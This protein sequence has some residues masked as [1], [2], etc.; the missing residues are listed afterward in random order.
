MLPI[1]GA[2]SSADGLAIG[3]NCTP[4]KIA[5]L[6]YYDLAL[7][8]RTLMLCPVDGGAIAT[9]RDSFRLAAQTGE[10]ML[11]GALAQTPTR[12]AAS[13]AVL[14]YPGPFQLDDLTAIIGPDDSAVRLSASGLTGTIDDTIGGTF[15]GGTAALDIV[16]L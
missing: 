13:R 14:R 15:E 9:Y 8:G 5:A 4:V 6:T 12:I 11:D 3:R 2:W 16:P 10:L 7:A 1:E